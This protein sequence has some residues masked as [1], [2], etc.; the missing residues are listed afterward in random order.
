MKRQTKNR[1]KRPSQARF[2]REKKRTNRRL[3]LERLDERAMMAANIF[4]NGGTVTIVGSNGSDQASVTQYPDLISVQVN[5]EVREFSNQQVKKI[6]FHGKNGNDKFVNNTNIRS[7]AYGGNG[8]DTLVGGSNRDVLSGGN[9]HDTLNGKAGDDRLYGG[10]GNDKL[11]GQSGNDRLYGKSGNDRLYGGTGND[12]LYGQAGND[13]LDGSKGHDQLFGGS[14]HDKLYG[15]AGHDKLYGG[16]GNDRLHGNSGN[17]RLYGNSGNDK[18]FGDSGHDR[19]YG[20]DGH[21]DI[22]G[23]SGNDY[24]RGGKG[25]DKIQGQAG[26]DTLRGDQG[27]DNLSG[28]DGAD[29]IWGGSDND[30]IS[31]GLGNDFLR[32]GSGTDR[33]YGGGGQ[34]NLNAENPQSREIREFTV[35]LSNDATLIV[36]G[37][38]L[39]HANKP[40]VLVTDNPHVDIEQ[41]GGILG[42]TAAGLPVLLTAEM[43]QKI[44]S[45]M[46]APDVT[47]L[48]ASNRLQDQAGLFMVVMS[49]D[50]LKEK[51]L[52]SLPALS[53][54]F[55]SLNNHQPLAFGLF[56]KNAAG[57]FT[58]NNMGLSL[59]DVQKHLLAS[60][61]NVMAQ[62]PDSS[63]GG[64]DGFTD[65]CKQ[66][67]YHQVARAN[68]GIEYGEGKLGQLIAGVIVEMKCV[69]QG[70][71]PW[72]TIPE[73]YGFKDDDKNDDGKKDDPPKGDYPTSGS[74]GTATAT[75]A[76][77]DMGQG[78]IQQGQLTSKEAAELKKK[79]DAKT[80]KGGDDFTRDGEKMR[81][82]SPPV[83][84]KGIRPTPHNTT[85]QP[86]SQ[87]GS[88]GTL[89]GIKGNMGSSFGIGQFDPNSDPAPKVGN[90]LDDR[91]QEMKNGGGS[92][93]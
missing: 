69:Q 89:T 9:G 25:N 34:D 84:N 7:Y 5:D 14:G 16:S 41:I 71:D 67:Y 45:L 79:A 83:F 74:N 77:P 4:Y 22:R 91:V 75:P 48:V 31:G 33:L 23:G 2:A 90:I 13:H 55:H 19:I 8:N 58:A 17:D 56:T 63:G 81:Q 65:W 78:G 47:E 29:K 20:S 72:D 73:A 10:T 59:G 11:L 66:A 76:P 26:N 28:G 80:G 62:A 44:T 15:Q 12:K 82:S 70:G 46:E 3:A 37:L 86:E 53:G 50:F 27:K 88:T 87:G 49:Q 18:L 51:L 85:P 64:T 1:N 61:S 36:K 52:G 21:D 93:F 40:Y 60:Q 32:G 42:K 57:G 54:A 38:L 39:H 24:L 35:Q 6:R 43:A 30:W 92:K 68:E